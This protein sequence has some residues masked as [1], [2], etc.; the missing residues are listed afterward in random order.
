MLVAALCSA[1]AGCSMFARTIERPTA[2]V[3]DV[4][5][6]TTGFDGVTGELQLEV[7]NPNPVGVPLSAIEWRLSI[8]GSRAA[9]GSVELSQTIPARGVAPVTTTLSVGVRDAIAVA[10]AL[11]SGARDYEIDATLRFSTAIGPI[12]VDIRHAGQ[13]E[14]G[15]L[16]LR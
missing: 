16:G 5:V 14:N 7:A 9:T 6:S 4:S 10:A 13:L 11:A 1:L 15:L 12:A 3:R 2:T 8:G